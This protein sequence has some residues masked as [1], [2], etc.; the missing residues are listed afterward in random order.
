[1]IF[2]KFSEMDLNPMLLK[3]CLL[4]SYAFKTFGL[5]ALTSK[6]ARAVCAAWLRIGHVSLRRIL[7]FFKTFGLVALT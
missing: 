6:K 2:K 5:V 4:V 1:M 7:L 3:P